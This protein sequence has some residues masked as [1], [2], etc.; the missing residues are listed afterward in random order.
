MG[1]EITDA[2]LATI[3]RDD[4][5]NQVVGRWLTDFLLDRRR[6]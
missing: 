1:D 2:A 3:E 6:A 5:D 4:V